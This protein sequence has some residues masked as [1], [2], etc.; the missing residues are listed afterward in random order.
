MIEERG[1]CKDGKHVFVAQY[2]SKG[3]RTWVCIRCPETR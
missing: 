1:G 3:K 2:D